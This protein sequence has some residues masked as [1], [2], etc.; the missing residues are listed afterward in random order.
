MLIPA[1]YKDDPGGPKGLL[2]LIR[3]RGQR[4]YHL[5]CFGRKSHYFEDGGCEHT[6]A[7]L[8]HLSAYGKEVTKLQPFGDGRNIPIRPR[9][10]PASR[11]PAELAEGGEQSRG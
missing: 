7:L 9:K 6:D 11:Q 8:E 5:A 3:I 4:W 10:R 1:E 2:L